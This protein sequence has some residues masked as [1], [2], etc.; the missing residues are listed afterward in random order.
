MDAFLGQIMLVGFDFVPRGW[1]LCN[2]QLLS[3]A[4]NSAL[5]A[6]LGTQYGGDGQSTFA[7]PD[8]RGR[9]PVHKGQGPGLRSYTQGETGGTESVTLTTNNLPPHAHPLI[10]AT[11]QSTDRPSGNVAPAIGG[12]YGDPSVSAVSAGMTGPAGNEQPVENRSPFLVLNYVIA[13]EGIF[14]SR[15]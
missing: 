8:L 3:I 2:G 9:V 11:D 5:F 12:A 1:A 6:L 10:G 7:L 15:D 14:P 13:L 4:Q